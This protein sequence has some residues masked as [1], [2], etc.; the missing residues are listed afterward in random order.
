MQTEPSTQTLLQ[1]MLQSSLEC[2]RIV[3]LID[4]VLLLLSQK[5]RT[6]EEKAIAEYFHKVVLI[7]CQLIVVLHKN[8]AE[9][10]TVLDE[11]SIAILGNL[12]IVNEKL[13]ICIEDLLKITRYNL[14]H[15]E[16]YYEYDYCAKLISSPGYLEELD[17]ALKDLDNTYAKA[18][19]EHR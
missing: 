19:H 11:K 17:N 8:P 9:P 10:K 15:L 14:N 4:E 18:Q 12:Q 2:A 13:R 16:Q 1:S 7:Q 5:R 6:L 3:E